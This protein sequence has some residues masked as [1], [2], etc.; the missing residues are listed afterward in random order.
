M[1]AAFPAAEPVGDR[2]ARPRVALGELPG[3][4]AERA[5]A[6]GL[7]FALKP[8]QRGSQRDPAPWRAATA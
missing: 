3:K 1:E 8:D 7:T 5:A 4:R 2:G 6:A